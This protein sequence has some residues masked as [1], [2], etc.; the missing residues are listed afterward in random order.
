[1]K[2]GNHGRSVVL[3]LSLLCGACSSDYSSSS[4]QSGGSKSTSSQGGSG[5]SSASGGR[6]SSGGSGGQ[7]GATTSVTGPRC[8]ATSVTPCG[9]D[10]VGSWTVTSGC[11]NLSGD[12]ISTGTGMGC[13]TF[14]VTG[15][16]QVTGSYILTS[17]NQFQD[18]TTTTG[19]ATVTLDHQ[20]LWM[21][22]T[23]TECDLISNSVGGLGFGDVNC[24]DAADGNGGCTCPAKIKQS[25]TMGL[26]VATPEN[27]GGPYTIKNNTLTVDQ[28]PLTQADLAYS[29]CV[30]SSQMTLTP[31]TT[32]PTTTG[33]IVLQKASS[34]GGGGGGSGGAGGSTAAG[35]I[36][37]AG[38]SSKA[39]GTTGT[40]G[41]TGAGGS[42]GAGGITGAGGSSKA[43]GS[44]GTAGSTSTGGSTSAGGST[45]AGGGS[46]AGGTTGA[47]GSTG[48]GGTTSA[49]GSTG[50]GG[51][52]AGSTGSAPCDI[53]QAANTPCVAAYSMVRPIYSSYK[54]PLYQVRS[55]ASSTSVQDIPIADFGYADSKVQDDFCAASGCTVSKIYDQSPKKN[56]LALS[57]DT[58]WLTLTGTP[59]SGGGLNQK[60]A[61]VKNNPKINIGGGHPVYGLKF[62]PGGGNAYRVLKPN[63]TATGDD[64]EYIY[65]IFDS[66]VYNAQ[67]CN[68]FGSAETTGNPDSFTSMEAIYYGNATTWGKGGG[69]G[70]WFSCDYEATISPGSTKVDTSIPSIS[71]AKY[72]TFILKGYSG[73]K[74]ALK[75][76][77]AT[78]GALTT[79]YDGARADTAKNSP[80]MKK[81]GSIILGTGGDGSAW[82]TGVWFEGV[83]TSGCSSDKAV[84]DAI[85]ANIV[86]AGFGK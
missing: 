18:N 29:Y 83:M 42:T 31:K 80:Y 86:A 9:G 70:P 65:A 68:D 28:N 36:T 41:N 56:D 45:G 10:V 58:Y 78:Q 76:G 72:A 63:G 60:E 55:K 40:A 19:T 61:D 27:S 62:M 20:C 47:G 1:M 15:S 73:G 71:I 26:L 74:I 22:G 35:G 51:G 79:Q 38:G 6:T 23:W 52:T 7:G 17:D 48:A 11:L 67:C 12:F 25:G 50:T 85:Q 30:A 77:D 53:L 32:S 54:G 33:S 82:S 34:G 64:P 59:R 44:T 57:P 66:T 43:G 13:D 24:V 8:S 84:D 37:G 69:N 39:G 49:G 75:F 5:G 4:N 81:Q 2:Y 21:S 3:A 46:K 14:K 16:V